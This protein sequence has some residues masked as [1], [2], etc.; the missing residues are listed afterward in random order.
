LIGYLLY[1]A[2]LGA[3]AAVLGSANPLLLPLGVALLAAEMGLKILRWRLF[4]KAYGM[5]VRSMDIV[6]SYLAGSFLAN[7]T[8]GH[9]GEAVRPYFLKKRYKGTSF[10]RL[11]P[12]I[13]V[14]R[15]L[16]VVTMLAFAAMFLLFFS[17]YVSN[18]MKVV[19]L[20]VFL[21]LI[22]AVFIIT[23][24]PLACR[25]ANGCF[26]LFSPIRAVRRAK[27]R[28]NRIL[29]NFYTGIASMHPAVL[30]KALGLTVVAWLLDGLILFSVASLLAP[31]TLTFL[32]CLGF[33]SFA[34]LGGMV[35]SLPG[36]LGSFEAIMFAFFLLLGFAEPL[37]LSITLLYR[38]IAYGLGVTASG[39]FFIREMR[40]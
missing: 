21:L 10:F 13:I 31:G 8:P 39:L 32:H 37:A 15:F 1:R 20:A 11:L 40:A 14:E 12:I 17:F 36:G 4:L 27:P 6:S 19:M 9:V 33:L 26:S 25:V 29:G 35:S 16:D 5:R 38:F 23:C 18:A 28:I 3:V 7:V 34:M 2:D 22:A 30:T 24:K